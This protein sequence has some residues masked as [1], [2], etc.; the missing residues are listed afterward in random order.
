M[1]HYYVF[2]LD[3][4]NFSLLPDID[5][6]AAQHSERIWECHLNLNQGSKLD[7]GT[8]KN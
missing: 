4:M 3:F 7:G 5:S 8:M 2:H 6:K 1:P